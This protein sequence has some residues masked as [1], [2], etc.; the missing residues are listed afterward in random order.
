MRIKIWNCCLTVTVQNNSAFELHKAV[1]QQ[2]FTSNH[3]L[4]QKNLANCTQ[5][6]LFN[7]AP[8]AKM[9]N[10]LVKFGLLVCMTSQWDTPLTIM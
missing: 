9:M 7:L 5:P 8:R 6:M 4:I 3:L 1:P 10:N 2:G